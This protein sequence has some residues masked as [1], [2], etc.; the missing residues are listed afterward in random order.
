MKGNLQY[1]LC[2]LVILV[3]TC[4]KAEIVAL[5]S[6][7]SR[8]YVRAGV[9]KCTLLA[10]VSRHEPRGGWEEFELIRLGGGHPHDGT[11]FCAEGGGCRDGGSEDS[12]PSPWHEIATQNRPSI[13]A[14]SR[15]L[16]GFFVPPLR[17][18]HRIADL[19]SP[20]GYVECE[21]SNA[22]LNSP[23]AL[24][25]S[26]LQSGEDSRRLRSIRVTNQHKRGPVARVGKWS[27]HLFRLFR[28]DRGDHLELHVLSARAANNGVR[29]CSGQLRGFFR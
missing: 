23:S 16:P 25:G 27:R 14:L 24:R 28:V 2:A 26:S 18:A 19:L 3:P 7:S 6:V 4:A 8:K 15:P 1:I 22:A 21:E 13:H 29:R 9:T 20:D 11:V 17:R 5:R 10:A 12:N